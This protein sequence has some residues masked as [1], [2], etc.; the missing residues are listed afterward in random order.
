MSTVYTI[1]M[2]K[3]LG[4]I[5]LCFIVVFS[6]LRIAYQYQEYFKAYVY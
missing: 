3:K 1:Y 5:I 2:L 6:L 4:W